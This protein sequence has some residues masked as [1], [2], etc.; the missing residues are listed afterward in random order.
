MSKR[1]TLQMIADKVGVTKSTVSDVL[2][3]RQSK[4]KVSENT[5]KK[6]HQAVKDL[7]YEPNG[8]ARALVTGKTHN[9][10]FL[11]S[12]ASSTCLA[13]TFF[14]SL[15]SGVQNSTKNRG[16]NCVV[17]CCDL[18]ST[19]NFMIP[20]KFSRKALDGIVIVGSVSTA[21]LK[22]L[23]ENDMPFIQIV[24]N[25]EFSAEKML[26]VSRYHKYDWFNAFEYLTKLGHKSIAVGG[27][28][29]KHDF[30]DY[31]EAVN[32]FNSKYSDLN[33]EFTSYSCPQDC[34]DVL[35]YAYQK[36]KQWVDLKNRPSALV[37]NGD[38]CIGFISAVLDSGL[39]CPG[40]LS[41]ICPC[42]NLLCESF[43]PTI[44]SIHFPVFDGGEQA[45][46]ILIDYIEKKIDW[47]KARQLTSNIWS[48]R[49]LIVRDSTS[50]P[51]NV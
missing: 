8:V 39:K 12:F 1:V 42:D 20:A 26:A 49:K 44:T 34:S 48:E 21:V 28:E 14:S 16:Y 19:E 46:S 23:I 22:K 7:G 45:A 31:H 33:V 41:V 15:L 24:E 3:K 38:W 47:E 30:K 4:I 6:I 9:I 40:D 37:G 13:N 29:S 51:G 5:K 27:L 35:E 32:N 36:G 50:K 11:L 2:R 25:P 43:R 18:S 10:G 17:D